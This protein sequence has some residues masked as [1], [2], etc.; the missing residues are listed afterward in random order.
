MPM[1]VGS[2]VKYYG[3]GDREAKGE[4]HQQLKHKHVGDARVSV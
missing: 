2:S 3:S 4:E 1:S